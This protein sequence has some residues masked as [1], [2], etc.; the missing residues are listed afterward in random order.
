MGGMMMNVK[1]NVEVDYGNGCVTSENPGKIKPVKP[2]CDKVTVRY[3]NSRNGRV[4]SKI[5]YDIYVAQSACE[6]PEADEETEQLIR[7]YLEQ[8]NRDADTGS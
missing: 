2:G 3:V 8:K 6:E 1:S 4:N 7:E 5:V